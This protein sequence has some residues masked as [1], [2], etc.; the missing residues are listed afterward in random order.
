MDDNLTMNKPCF[1]RARWSLLLVAAAVH[2]S[3]G[4]ES[5]SIPAADA[6]AADLG[7]EMGTVNGNQ[8]AGSDVDM[9][10]DEFQTGTWQ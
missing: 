1:L 2:L 5:A 10:R 3:C 7:A 8:D 6:I 9:N 4:S